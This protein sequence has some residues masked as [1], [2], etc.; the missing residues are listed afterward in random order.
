MVATPDH[1]LTS[2]DARGSAEEWLAVLRISMAGT[3]LV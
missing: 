2:G 1:A 3:Q